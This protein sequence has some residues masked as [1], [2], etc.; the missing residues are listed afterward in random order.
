MSEKLYLLPQSVQMGKVPPSWP[1]HI[2]C[3]SS[4][5]PSPVPSYLSGK[6]PA[7]C[8]QTPQA[9]LHRHLQLGTAVSMTC[10]TSLPTPIFWSQCKLLGWSMVFPTF[11]VL[12]PCCPFWA[13]CSLLACQHLPFQSGKLPG[14][15]SI[16][17]RSSDL[18]HVTVLKISPLDGFR[19]W[20][21]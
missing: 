18:L 11:Q 1:T 14:D 2:L 13:A 4:H 19:N 17:H 6:C 15:F 10:V 7:G 9:L 12:A 20:F 8:K 5:T 16:F 3:P 21:P